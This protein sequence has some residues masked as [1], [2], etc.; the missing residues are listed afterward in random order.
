MSLLVHPDD[1]G[2]TRKWDTNARMSLEIITDEDFSVATSTQRTLAGE[3]APEWFVY[4]RNEPGVQ[5]FHQS[6]VACL[7]DGI[8]AGAGTPGAVSNGQGR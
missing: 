3:A 7:D 1:L 5:H 6:V 4:G 2:K 8:V